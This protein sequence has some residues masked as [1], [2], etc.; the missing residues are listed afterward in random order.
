MKRV[1]P[2]GVTSLGVALRHGRM[3]VGYAMAAP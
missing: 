1:R 3:A 2:T